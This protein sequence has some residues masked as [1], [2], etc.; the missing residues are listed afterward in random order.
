MDL[1]EAIADLCGELAML[2]KRGVTG[3][4]LSFLFYFV[5][6]VT[7]SLGS[8]VVYLLIKFV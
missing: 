1:I 5:V 4:V 6:L 7:L 2:R 8:I 3:A